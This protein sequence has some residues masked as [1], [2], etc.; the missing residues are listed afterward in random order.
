MAMPMRRRKGRLPGHLRQRGKRGTAN[1][2]KLGDV[3][4][5]GRKVGR[6]A[7]P[8]YVKGIGAVE[9]GHPAPPSRRA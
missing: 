2:R 7:G 3:S 6:G 9:R 8:S 4:R 1:G 5:G